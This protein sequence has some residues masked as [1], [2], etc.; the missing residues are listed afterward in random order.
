MARLCLVIDVPGWS[1]EQLKQ[2]VHDID[3]TDDAVPIAV[4]HVDVQ[5]ILTVMFMGHLGVTY[6]TLFQ[7]I[8]EDDEP[9]KPWGEV[10]P[11]KIEGLE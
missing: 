1:G 9:R 3:A 10:F 8:Q 6:R 5:N 7:A 2:A 11:P 4:E